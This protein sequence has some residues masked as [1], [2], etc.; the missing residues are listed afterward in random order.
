VGPVKQPDR[1]D[2]RQ[3]DDRRSA[4]QPVNSIGEVHCIRG[5]QHHHC[6]EEDVP[7]P[8]VE[9]LRGEGDRHRV[10]GLVAPQQEAEGE[11]HPCLQQ[12]LGPLV[13]ALAGHFSEVIEQPDQ[14]I[15]P[16]ER[17][18][19]PGRHRQRL[20]PQKRDDEQG[21]GDRQQ[22][23]EPAPQ[24]PAR[25][26]KQAMDLLLAYLA[27]SRSEPGEASPRH[28]GKGDPECEGK[29]ESSE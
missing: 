9:G 27:L 12:E 7:G 26:G 6:G 22:H 29:D 13:Q 10:E 5:G 24:R 28:P 21:D 11:G 17:K 3:R 14:T 25:P 15:G 23:R 1:G 16:G 4:G 2:A 8:E 19:P 20:P 18:H